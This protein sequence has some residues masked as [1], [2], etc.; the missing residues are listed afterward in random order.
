[1]CLFGRC[2][3]TLDPIWNSWIQIWVVFDDG[4]GVGLTFWWSVREHEPEFY[5]MLQAGFNHLL[6]PAETNQRLERDPHEYWY[7][8]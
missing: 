6:K 7:T 5:L 2:L 8:S 4:G 1:M 3:L